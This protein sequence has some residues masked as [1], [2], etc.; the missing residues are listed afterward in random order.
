MNFKE[1]MAVIS[2][3]VW[4]MNSEVDNYVYRF[5]NG[6]IEG[7]HLLANPSSWQIQSFEEDEISAKW[8]IYQKPKKPQGLWQTNGERCAMDF[9]F[10][11]MPAFVNNN[12][13]ARW[14]KA[15]HTFFCLKRHP[16]ARAWDSSA[17]DTWYIV[18]RKSVGAAAVPLCESPTSFSGL[19]PEFLSKEYA[20]DAIADIGPFVLKEMF[21]TF[22]GIY[23]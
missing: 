4:V 12:E 2:E 7:F 8:K 3:D 9:Q 19:S 20:Q 13:R 17:S 22:Q 10:S 14:V 16:L 23:K 1:A 11:A 21:E 5:K 18:H 15:M 6:I